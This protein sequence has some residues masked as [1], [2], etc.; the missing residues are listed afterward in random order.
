VPK[1]EPLVRGLLAMSE[2]KDLP[3]EAKMD[4]AADLIYVSELKQKRI[5]LANELK[6]QIKQLKGADERLHNID[7]SSDAKIKELIF[8][9]KRALLQKFVNY[10][11]DIRIFAKNKADIYIS[12][13]SFE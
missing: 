3:L 11:K 2:Q 6:M 13:K 10:D 7:I 9:Q 12:I 5:D 1:P 8:K 4:I